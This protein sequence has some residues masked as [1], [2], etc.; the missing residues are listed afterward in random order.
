MFIIFVPL[1]KDY[2]HFGCLLGN[3]L[4][5]FSVKDAI[6]LIGHPSAFTHTG[7]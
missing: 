5:Y 3:F 2:L 6:T 1:T 7:I 4:L